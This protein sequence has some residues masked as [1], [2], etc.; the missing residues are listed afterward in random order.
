MTGSKLV[1]PDGHLQEAGGIF[2]KDGSAW[3]YGHMQNPED[4]EFNYVKEADYISGA[5][6]M[7]RRSLWEE[8]GGFDERFAPAYY[9]DADL[10]FEVRKHGYKVV[11]QPL[12]V[13]VHFEGISNG[14]DLTTGQKKYQ[15]ENQQKFYDKWKNVLETEHFPNGENVFLAKDRSRSRKQILVV[16]VYVTI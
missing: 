13:V 10:A 3:N 12:S 1:Y 9:E 4:P 7:I 6:I 2:W 8:I 14:T 11:Y 16:D 15:V 5:S